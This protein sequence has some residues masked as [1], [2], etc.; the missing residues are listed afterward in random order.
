[1]NCKYITP[2]KD[3]ECGDLPNL[4]AIH[5]EYLL[6]VNEKHEN[7]LK[8]LLKQV[9]K[10]EVVPEDAKDLTM[11]KGPTDIM[12]YDLVF[13]GIKLGRMEFK[14]TSQECTITFTPSK[15]LFL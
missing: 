1:M 3:Y 5:E 4:S 6:M 14:L 15:D 11:V 2:L 12:D 7:L 8:E 10:R 9:L 13:R